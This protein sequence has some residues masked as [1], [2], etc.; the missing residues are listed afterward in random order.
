[1][2]DAGVMTGSNRY[3]EQSVVSSLFLYNREL[4][5][6][7]VDKKINSSTPLYFFISRL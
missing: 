6:K 7:L 2:I 1:M 3:R 5:R 4:E